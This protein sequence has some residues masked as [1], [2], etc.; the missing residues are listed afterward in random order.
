MK[1]TVFPAHF[2]RNPAN[3]VRYDRETCNGCKFERANPTGAKFCAKLGQKWGN[4]C[5]WYKGN[6]N[7][8]K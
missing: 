1:P 8:F 5:S 7:P 6:W 3:H 4:R 2:Y